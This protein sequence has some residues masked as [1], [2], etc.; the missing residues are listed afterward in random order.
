MTAE[1]ETRERAL[2]E[3]FVSLADTLVADYD[4]IELLATAEHRLC[5]RCSRSTRPGCC[6]PT[7]AARCRSCVLHRAGAPDGAVPAAERARDRAWTA[8]APAGRSAR[9]TC[10]DDG[11]WP[12]FIAHTPGRPATAPCTRCRCGCASET[13]GALNLFRVRSRRARAGGSAH[14]PGSGRR[15][16]H[17]HP[18]GT[19]HP[20]PRGPRR[21]AAGRAEQ[22]DDHRAGQGHPRRARPA[23]H[24]PGLR[25]CSAAT[26]APPTCG[27]ATSPSASSPEPPP[28]RLF[29]AP[30]TAARRSSP[31]HAGGLSR[32][33][34]VRARVRSR[35]GTVARRAGRSPGQVREVGRRDVGGTPGVNGAEPVQR[36]QVGGVE[37]RR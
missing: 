13:I 27:S 28:P 3:A 26:P 17:R 19:R 24:G 25:R 30:S 14:R 21:A 18:A 2:A 29:S 37:P 15:G 4:V 9:P 22:P 20:P 32:D 23:R 11:R 31:C 10:A 33:V 35:P 12:R 6:C 8:S 16:H 5:R 36:D 34:P 1:Q 7:S